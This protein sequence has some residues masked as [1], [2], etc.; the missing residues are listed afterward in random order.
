MQEQGRTSVD[1]S[2]KRWRDPPI[3][4]GWPVLIWIA[5]IADQGAKQGGKQR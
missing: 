4:G 2:D 3:K 5:D 1:N